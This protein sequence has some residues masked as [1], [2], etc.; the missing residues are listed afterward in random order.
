V[1]VA[2]ERLW[3][4]TEPYRD[5]FS[6]LD[7]DS[8]D[9][10]LPWLPPALLSITTLPDGGAL[11]TTQQLALSRLE[12]ARLCAAGVWL[13]G[14]LVSRVT[15]RGFLRTPLED[16]R[17]MLHEAREEAGHGLMFLEM[18]ER[19]GLT[20]APLLGSTALLTWVARRLEP[21]DAEFWAMVYVGESI[22]NQFVHRALA[23]VARGE[24]ICPLARE[25][26]RLHSRDEARHLATARALLEARIARMGRLR[27]RAFALALGWLL[28][29]FLEATLYPSAASLGAIGLAHAGRIA[30]SVRACPRRHT[31][32]HACAAPALALMAR[33]GLTR[34]RVHA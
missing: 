2:L 30:R 29:R 5:P 8:A 15:A 3:R 27:R 19:A 1:S 28:E 34:G 25:V 23:L 6:E 32:A 4:R 20:G 16:A 33:A 17:V 12:F 24:R 7:F 21:S 18:I 31:L 13:E 14:L 9:A 22:T 11:T 26:M 10:S